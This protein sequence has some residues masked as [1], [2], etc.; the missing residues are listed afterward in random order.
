MYF[1]LWGFLDDTSDDA[2]DTKA[3]GSV[4]RSGRFPGEGNGNPLQYSCLENPLGRGAWQSM[5]PQA[6]RYDWVTEHTYF[7]LNSCVEDRKG[8]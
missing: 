7:I 4:P 3:A 5:G 2:G 6:V 8:T 1:I